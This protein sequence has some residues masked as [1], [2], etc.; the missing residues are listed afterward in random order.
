TIIQQV[1]DEQIVWRY[2][3]EK[4]HL[5]GAVTFHELAPRLTRILAVVE[6]YPQGF[7][8]KTGNIWRAVGRRVQVEFKRYVRQVMTSTI[9][10]PD[11]VEGWRGE[12]RDSEVVRSHEEALEEEQRVDTQSTEETQAEDTALEAED[13]SETPAQHDALGEDE[14][15][16]ESAAGQA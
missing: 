12:I 15:E 13:P 5:D 16:D 1:P 3:G 4:G 9:L 7:M 6:Y 14:A 2:T 8:E 11:R 10:D